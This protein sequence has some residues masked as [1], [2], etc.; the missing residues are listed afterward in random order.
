MA[1]IKILTDQTTGTVYTYHKVV[2]IVINE[3]NEVSAP[4]RSWINK[5]K[6]DAQERS[7][8]SHVEVLSTPVQYDLYNLAQNLIITNPN[9]ILFGGVIEP[10]VP[11]PE[12]D[13][14]KIKKKAEITAARNEEMYADKTTTLGV[15]ASTEADNS[16]LSLAI[17]VTQL[18]AAR[19]QPAECGYND[20][21]GNWSIYTL[22]QLEQIAL[23][24]ANQVIPAYAKESTLFA[25]VDAATT[26]EQ[27]AAIAW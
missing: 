23:E 15:F 21:A 12:L 16:K 5:Q 1:I 20:A 27:V 18:A 25:Q 17:Q 24:I 10:D 14:Q 3:N 4:I 11:M 6:H 9:S 26:V 2:A 13:S 7:V 22:A 19:N 8:S